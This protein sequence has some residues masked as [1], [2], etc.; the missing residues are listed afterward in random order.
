MKQL[1]AMGNRRQYYRNS[2]AS[3]NIPQHQQQT[4]NDQINLSGTLISQ[5]T[6]PAIGINLTPSLVNRQLSTQPIQSQILSNSS[7]HTHNNSQ[8]SISSL[9][10]HN[11]PNSS[12]EIQNESNELMN[13]HIIASSSVIGNNPPNNYINNPGNKLPINYNINN[14]FN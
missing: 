8:L 3:R 2:N 11:N 4:L 12:Y 5:Q 14:Y 6:Q 10:Q 7:I 1:S 13:S 9:G